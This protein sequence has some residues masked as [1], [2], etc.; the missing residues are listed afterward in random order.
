M[1]YVSKKDN[2][3][4]LKLK[5]I[6]CINGIIKSPNRETLDKLR[7]YMKGT[8]W[9]KKKTKVLGTRSH[10]YSKYLNGH[11]KRPLNTKLKL[12]NPTTPFDSLFS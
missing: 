5:V 4:G 3:R 6:R 9:K 8:F 7:S 1:R 10:V 2:N 12:I 11:L